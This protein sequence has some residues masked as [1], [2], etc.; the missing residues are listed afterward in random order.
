MNDD[1]FIKI[2]NKKL[3]VNTIKDFCLEKGNSNGYINFVFLI[4]ILLTSFT[5]IILIFIRK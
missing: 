4:S 1:S 2:E 5:W 3:P